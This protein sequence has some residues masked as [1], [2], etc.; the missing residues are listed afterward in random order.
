[1]SLLSSY[2]RNNF[3]GISIV[4]ILFREIWKWDTSS[5]LW[6]RIRLEAFTEESINLSIEKKTIEFFS[7][8]IETTLPIE[9]KI[10]VQKPLDDY[11]QVT[12]Y[13]KKK[14]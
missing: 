10:R 2:Y 5:H 6:E 7:P 9:E 13:S 14:Q 8:Q 12:G 3:S 11:K 4:T 1:M